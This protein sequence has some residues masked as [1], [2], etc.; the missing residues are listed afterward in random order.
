[1]RKHGDRR[2]I[3]N[4]KKEGDDTSSLK[5][6]GKIDLMNESKYNDK[7]STSKYHGGG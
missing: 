3:R 6:I 7:Y 1:M 4:T 2:S 5:S